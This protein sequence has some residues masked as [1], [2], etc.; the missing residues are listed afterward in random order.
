MAL[1]LAVG[2]GLVGLAS[3]DEPVNWFKWLTPAPAKKDEA[4]KPDLK[5]DLT[6][7]AAT[8]TNNNRAV[9]AKVD[10]DRRQEVCLRLRDIAIATGDED[11]L[12][13]ADLL[14]QRAYDV[15]LAVKNQRP[16]PAAPEAKKGG[17]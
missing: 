13:K 9:K 12:R 14:D 5:A 1:S 6:P 17:R 8:S 10:L 2:L 3:A 4:K 15:Y 7:I 11:L 16:T